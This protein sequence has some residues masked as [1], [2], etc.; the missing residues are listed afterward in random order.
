MR[1]VVLALVVPCLAGCSG[2]FQRV[3]PEVP[4]RY[5]A[6]TDASTGLSVGSAERDVTPEVGGY[7]AGFD[8]ARTSTGVASPLKVRALVLEAGSRR[9]AIVGVDNLGLMRE[10]VDWIKMGLAGFANGDVFV[11]SSHTH[12][13]PDMIGLWGFWF[14]SSGRDRDYLVRLR[15]ATTA[16][17]AEARA[18]AAPARLLRGQ[19]ML[20]PSGLVKNAN[21]SS[22]F[23]RRVTVL[24]AQALDD[25]RPLGS[26]LHLACHPEVQPRRNTA[27]SADFVGALCD[28]WRAR[29]HGQA[30]FANGALGAMVSPD[31]QPRDETGVATFGKGACDLCE[32]ALREAEP[33]VVD[34]VEVR[35]ADVYLP[36]IS[37]GF[38]VGRLTT[39][40]E[41]ELFDGAAR[42]TVGFLRLGSFEAVAVPGEMEPALAARLRAQ[43]RRPDLVV[44]GL[45]DDEV[46]YLL[47][48]QEARDPEF[49]Y[50]RSMSPCLSAG[51]LVSAAITGR[52]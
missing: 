25:G 35:R 2:I 23:D 20:P 42:S 24:H 17:V 32:K 40:L 41:R 33:L 29:G 27:I 9:I 12:A 37:A 28:E 8:P 7:L 36:M 51:E 1:L 11:C 38:R 43:L 45:C 15:E 34:E 44:L 50:E 21:R 46:G 31:V 22:V 48:E 49:A 18:K 4:A 47:R 5:A 19:A 16:A 3:R 30:V 14:M 13:G 39:V 6:L 10:D 52:P 26:L